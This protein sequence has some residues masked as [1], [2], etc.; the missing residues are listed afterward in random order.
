MKPLYQE[1]CHIRM[2]S[3]HM[4]WQVPVVTFLVRLRQ[5]EL[6]GARRLSQF[7]EKNQPE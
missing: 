4:W 3:G 6:F 1:R 2:L 7:L 5:E